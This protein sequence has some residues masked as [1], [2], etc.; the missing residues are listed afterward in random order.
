MYNSA[1]PYTHIHTHTDKKTKTETA[2]KGEKKN[3]TQKATKYKLKRRLDVTGKLVV[4]ILKR[5]H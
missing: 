2:Q 5:V 1:R 4:L 3:N